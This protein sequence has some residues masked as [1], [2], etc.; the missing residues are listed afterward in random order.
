MVRKAIK[1]Y[2]W[3][4]GKYK[5]L[6]YYIA[7]IGDCERYYEP[8]MGSASIFLNKAPSDAEFLSDV[9]SGLVNLMKC[10]SKLENLN[11]MIDIVSN[12]DFDKKQFE[13]AK[14]RID[15]KEQSAVPDG[16]DVLWAADVYRSIVYSFNSLRKSYR[17]TE[18]PFA[19]CD[20]YAV[21]ER[22][23]GVSIE[24]KDAFLVLDEIKRD[25]VRNADNTVILL[26][27]PYLES[28]MNCKN[29]YA[30]GLTEMEQ[31]R[32]LLLI[33]DMKARV[34][35]CGYRSE[36]DGNDFYD[37]VLRE[38]NAKKGERRW[39][40]YHVADAKPPSLKKNNTRILREFVWLN[41][42]PLAYCPSVKSVMT[43]EESG[44]L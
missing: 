29:V 25:N 5:F 7:L 40:C 24:K 38:G 3:F 21:N 26:D 28:L 1:A 14:K 44:W 15:I 36:N 4:G 19:N 8:F 2:P 42:D 30:S 18:N 39:R 20:L 31:E 13:A 22:L 27:P 23:D 41:Y 16:T 37:R 9:D 35:L 6:K 34:I 43:L 32:L 11:R 12:L 10:L 33:R 17:F